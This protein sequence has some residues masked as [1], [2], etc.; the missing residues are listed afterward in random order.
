MAYR[1][2]VDLQ[3]IIE[4]LSDHLYSRP[5]VFLRELL[6]N[7]VDAQS[8]RHKIEPTHEGKITVAVT[9]RTG[10]PTT[11]VFADDGV[12]L[13]EEEVHQFLATIGA[14]S[15]RDKK[16]TGP[17]DYLGQFGI[18]L[19]S[20]FLV[21]D[22]VVAVSRSAKGGPAV[23]WRGRGDGTYEVRTLEADLAPGTQVYLTAKPEHEER[24]TPNE[25]KEQL[26]HYGSLLPIPIYLEHGGRSECL[27][28]EVPPWRRHYTNS[29]KERRELLNYGQEVLGE[30]FIDAIKIQ[31]KGGNL[32]G[33]AYIVGHATAAT[34]SKGHR[35]YLKNMLL[36]EQ[37]D[38]L[39]PDWAFFV[40]LIANT[41]TLRPTASR[42][43]FYENQ[44]L[45]KT[46]D[47]V[48]KLLRDY[49]LDLARNDKRRFH[50]ILSI[51]EVALKGLALDDDDCF[52]TFIELFPF[53]TARG[54]M[55]LQEFRKDG[56]PVR[57]VPDVDQFRQV[58][59][60]SNAQG[61]NLINA[62]YVHNAELL[63]K[64]GE[65]VPEARV[66]AVDA[67]GLAEALDDLPDEDRERFQELLT[68]ADQT[69]RSFHCRTE[70]RNFDPA[71]TPALY[72]SSSESRFL[73][74]MDQA[75]EMADPLWAGVLGSMREPRAMTPMDQLC[76]NGRNPLIRQLAKLASGKAV[77]HCLESLYLQALMMARQPL[78]NKELTLLS[79]SLSGLVQLAVKGNSR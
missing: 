71:E 64:Y 39:L 57:F 79:Q 61:T 78:G 25:L 68:T 44:Q 13:S 12:G 2:Q 43:G 27:N 17:K 46:R 45:Q 14:S 58:A 10:K 7:A 62:G 4:L 55:T 34:S 41:E 49:L 16:S 50:T 18:G 69:L 72:L 74:S 28:D 3:G 67:S 42:E 15:K 52:N 56:S 65:M 22:E 19:L 24:F 11:M 75:R 70:V 30:Q 48:G 5:E 73:R 77:T 40:R 76:L 35:I 6:Q 51:H 36:T 54:T 63:A 26:Q 29:E 47:A 53:E 31:S 1:F 59:R 8:A 38:A 23:E 20:C 21:S 60:V 9:V 32:D 37:G 33:V 66:E